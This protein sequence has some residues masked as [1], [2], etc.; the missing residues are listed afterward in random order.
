M[1]FMYCLSL[2]LFLFLGMAPKTNA[3]DWEDYYI[4]GLWWIPGQDIKPNSGIAR[5]DGGVLFSDGYDAPLYGVWAQNDATC[6][7]GSPLEN[8]AELYAEYGE[9][10]VD[11]YR[12]SLNQLTGRTV[13]ST[14]VSG[15]AY[16]T[17]DLT[18]IINRT[19]WEN[20]ARP[21]PPGG[22][23]CYFGFTETGKFVKKDDPPSQELCSGCNPGQSE[24]NDCFNSGGTYDWVSCQCGGSPIVIDILGNGFDLTNADNGVVFDLNGKG[25]FERIAW[26]SVGS[27]DAWLALDRNGNGA[28]DSGKEL[29]GN[30]TDQPIPTPGQRGNGFLALAVF[31]LPTNGG[32]FDGRITQQDLIFSQLRLW[33]DTNHN[34]VSESS[35]LHNLASLGVTRLDLDYQ[36]SRL[37][38]QHG[39]RFSI[40]QKFEERT[41]LN[42][43]V[44]RGMFT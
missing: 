35:E 16:G 23:G 20:C 39:N 33:Q 29:F 15:K 42:S 10:W 37:R 30:F 3:Q 25:S 17:G 5:V 7:N 19:Q 18:P 12:Y 9:Q 22:G 11:A 24:L 41:E 36:E 6:S 8:E 32:N 27:D 31:D 26:S 14:L 34:G 28:I 40:E 44:G 38:D 13:I 21:R 43:D 2:L 4:I 1:K